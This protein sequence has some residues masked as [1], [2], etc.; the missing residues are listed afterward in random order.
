VPRIIDDFSSLSGWQILSGNW[1]VSQGICR[2]SDS[3]NSWKEMVR[4]GSWTTNGDIR[5]KFK[6]VQRN[7]PLSAIGINFRRENSDSFYHIDLSTEDTPSGRIKYIR[8]F[9]FSNGEWTLIQKTTLNWEPLNPNDPWINLKVSLRCNNVSVFVDD[10]VVS[11]QAPKDDIPYGYGRLLTN[12]P[13]SGE[14]SICSLGGVHEIDEFRLINEFEY[15]ERDILDCIQQAMELFPVD[16]N[17]VYLSGFSMGGVGAYVLGLHNPGLFAA[18]APSDGASDLVYDYDFIQAHYPVKPGFPYADINDGRVCETW[19]LIAGREDQP[20]LPLDTPLIKDNSARYVLENAINLPMRI[21]HGTPDSIFPNNYKDLIVLWW[22]WKSDNS[23]WEQVQAPAPYSPATSTY[24]NGKDIYNILTS[25]SLSGPYYGEYVTNPYLGHG[26]QEPYNVTAEFFKSK[27][28]NRFPRELAY[29]TYDDEESTTYW[30][31]IKK[32][33]AASDQAGAARVKLVEDQNQVILNVRNVGETTLD[34][35]QAGIKIEAGKSCSIQLNNQ[36]GPHAIPVEDKYG[37]TTLRLVYTWPP[38]SY[39]T[40]K[41]DGSTLQEG[42]DFSRNGAA[43]VF[44][45]LDTSSP[46]ILAIEASSAIPPNLLKN[47]GFEEAGADERKPSGWKPIPENNGALYERY[48]ISS[49]SGAY[50]ARIKNPV[51]SPP[52]NYSSWESEPLD[53]GIVGGKKYYI[54]AFTRTRLLKGASVGVTILWYNASGQLIGENPVAQEIK[55]D[56]TRAEW[57]SIFVE[58]SAPTGAVSAKVSLRVLGSSGKKISGSAWFDDV[59]LLPA[60]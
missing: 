39:L 22:R 41:L 5:L 52:G 23:G 54:Y 16:E 9:K 13:L 19:R 44:P 46:H 34:L 18:V 14:V 33:P 49:H 1:S 21:I 12:P 42:K 11:I 24:A 15:G 10:Y 3:S 20:D 25:W 28:R 59:V 40:V 51:F 38:A 37:K 30:M 26:F 36:T 56:F 7:A 32:Y 43:L 55:D 45:T 47:S 50:S 6:E 17:R 27:V 60:E 53:Q 29:K 58:A 2:Q 8:L 35:L 57:K 31:K 4:T 48:A